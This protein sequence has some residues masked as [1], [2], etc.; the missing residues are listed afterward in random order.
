MNENEWLARQFEEHRPRLRA[1]AYRMLGSRAE[2]DDAV[3]DTW[4]RLNR[5]GD[6]QI[7]N[8]GGWL[9]TVV[10]RECLHLLRSRRSRREDLIGTELPDPIITADEGLG[11]EQE[12]LL[13][14]SVGL[15][16]LLVLDR[17]P[18]AERVA[19]VLHDAFQLP[20]DEIARLIDRQPAAA[21]QL[22]SRARRRVR[23]A[24]LAAAATDVAGQRKVVD[25]FFA[26]ARAG[27]FDALVKLLDPDIVLRADFGPGL[28]QAEY[29]GTAE[30]SRFA[31]AP[32]GAEL[33]PVLVNGRIGKLVTIDGRP[34]SILVFTV[35]DGRVVEIDAVRTG[36]AARAAR[37]DS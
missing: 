19:F 2:A 24:G 21:R 14:E 7:D 22:A 20:F 8:L 34:F 3:Q 18:P 29:R 32:R 11:P 17:L 12:A 16:L 9:T 28:L 15:A 25:A 5:A 33:H 13:A 31:R 4:L 27:D 35:A 6:D 37:A 36:S 10:T 30:V 26:A 1:L 23:D